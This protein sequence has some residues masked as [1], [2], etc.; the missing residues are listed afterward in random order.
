M[1]DNLP[2]EIKL[3][4]THAY[5][6]LPCT[7]CGGWT[8]KHSVK[9]ETDNILVC[10]ICLEAGNIDERLAENARK[11]ETY[12]AAVRSLI[13]R[14]R[15]PTIEQWKAEIDRVER[16]GEMLHLAREM[17]CAFSRPRPD[18]TMQTREQLIEAFEQYHPEVL[19]LTEEEIEACLK[20]A[21]WR[22]KAHEEWEERQRGIEAKRLAGIPL[23]DDEMVPF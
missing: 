18:N 9:A 11:L 10:E 3:V 7:I 12:A 21:E 8:E 14:L 16:V 15:V 4:E 23:T 6:R 1:T 20:S 5:Q 22:R 19:P 2:I 13:G 17:E